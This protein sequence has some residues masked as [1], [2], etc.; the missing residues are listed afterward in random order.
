MDIDEI[1]KDKEATEFYRKTNNEVLRQIAALILVIMIAFPLDVYCYSDGTFTYS[2]C[3]GVQ[4]LSCS[5]NVVMLLLYINLIRMVRNRYKKMFESLEEYVKI[6]DK[7]AVR[8]TNRFI[9]LHRGRCELSNVRRSS[10]QLLCNQSNHLQT[11]RLLYI[12]MY[13]TVQ[14]IASYFGAPVLFQTL[15]VMVSSVLLLYGAFHS[16]TMLI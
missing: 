7:P 11:L 2:L 1:I 10:L 3:H 5:L 13:D 8:H 6:M 15:S 16:L 9:I 12:K 14:L 4:Y